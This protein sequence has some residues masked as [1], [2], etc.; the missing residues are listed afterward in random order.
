MWGRY[1]YL[2][3][4]SSSLSPQWKM[5]KLS[6][7]ASQLPVY[8]QLQLSVLKCKLIYCTSISPVY[9]RTLSL[10]LAEKSWGEVKSP[11]AGVK[12]P[13]IHGRTY[14]CLLS[15][16]YKYS[17]ALNQHFSASTDILLAFP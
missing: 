4:I 6:L 9:I 8:A 13:V 14:S 12:S 15:A 2:G 7:T 10:M 5:T 11:K 16:V 3:S 17:L 1:F